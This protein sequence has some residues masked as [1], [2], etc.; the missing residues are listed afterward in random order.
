M[1]QRIMMFLMLLFP[2]LGAVA[3]NTIAIGNTEMEF[4]SLGQSVNLPVTMDNTDDIVAVE[5]ILKL[6]RGGSIN[7]D[8]CQLIASRADGHQISAACID[9]ENNIYKVTA[10]STSN[11]PFKASSGQLMTLDV[12]TSPDWLDGRTYAVTITKALLCKSNG[13]NVCTDFESGAIVVPNTPHAVIAF[14]ITGIVTT[15]KKGSG[16][17]YSLNITN[18]GTATTGTIEMQL[19]DWMSLQ[20][21]LMPIE[22]GQSAMAVI[23]MNPSGEANTRYDGYIGVN[24]E[25]GNNQILPYNVTIVSDEKGT[26]VFSVCDEYTYYDESAPKVQNATIEVRNSSTAEV[27]ATLNTGTTG[28]AQVTLP[29]GYYEF[30]VTAEGHETYT[31]NILIYPGQTIERTVNLSLGD[32]INIEYQVVETEEGDG[33]VIVTEATLEVAVPAPQVTISAPGR[34]KM[35]DVAVG[36]HVDIQVTLTNRG[37]IKARDVTLFVPE[38]EGFRWEA[39]NPIVFDLRPQE[40][41]FITIRYTREAESEG[42]SIMWRATYTWKCGDEPK[43][44]ECKAFTSIGTNC[45]PCLPSNCIVATIVQD[46]DVIVTVKMQ[47]NQLLTLTRQAFEGTLTIENGSD[48][49]MDD[50]MLT[51]TEKMPNGTLATDREFD[52]SYTEFTGFTGEVSGRWTLA[53]GEKGVLKVKFIPTKYAAPIAAIDY[54]FGGNL[55]FSVDGKE[56]HADLAEQ[57]M[58]VKPTPELNLD[59]FMQRDVIADDA[60]TKDVVEPAEEAEFA[61]LISNV[62]YGDAENLKMVTAQPEIVDNEESLFLQYS[63]TSS[64]LNG[65]EKSLAFGKSVTTDFGTL[66]ARS[67]AYAQWWMTSSLL[68]HFIEYNVSYTQ[69][70][71]SKNPNLS[72]LNEV[73][74]HELI[75]SVV[76]EGNANADY[77]FAV[78]E[79][80]DEQNLPDI[81]YLTDGTTVPIAIGQASTEEVD[82]NLYTITVEAAAAGWTYAKMKDPTAGTATIT[83]VTRADGTV[84]PLRNIWQ[85]WATVVDKKRAIHEDL[86]HI[87]DN[88]K[89]GA[90]TYT[91]R[92]K[93]KPAATLNIVSVKING[94]NTSNDVSVRNAEVESVELFFT[95]DLREVKPRA[96]SLVNQGEVVEMTNVS[97]GID[98]KRLWVDLSRVDHNDGF[99][100]LTV[101]TALITDVDGNVGLT[102]SPI[103]WIEQ[104]AKP[105][106]LNLAFNYDK[107][108][109]VMVLAEEYQGEKTTYNKPQVPAATYKYGTTLTLQVTPAYGYIF[110][111]WSID[112][113]IVSTEMTY[114]YYLSAN[115]EL[116]LFFDRE[117]FNL[118][119]SNIVDIDDEGL[120]T[121]GGMVTGAGSGYY[122]YG[123]EVVLTAEP[124]PCHTFVGWYTD[125][126]DVADN[127]SETGDENPAAARVAVSRISRT[128]AINGLKLLTTDATYTYIMSAELTLYPVFHRL[129][130]VNGDKVFS[131]ADA[132]LVANYVK[133]GSAENF[134]KAEAD[135]DCNGKIDLDDVLLIASTVKEKATTTAKSDCDVKMLV[136]DVFVDAGGSSSVVM[137]FDLGSKAYTAYQMDIIY[138]EGISSVSRQDGNPSIAREGMVY[139]ESHVISSVRTVGGQDRIQCFADGSQTL[140]AQE[141][142]LL[143]LPVSALKSV[144]EGTYRA[145]IAPVE[146]VLPDA[147]AERPDTI[148]FNIRVTA[149]G[150]SAS[151]TYDLAEGW[152]WISSN[153]AAE[154]TLF[155]NPVKT[156]VDRLLSQTE[157]LISDPLFGM[158]GNLTLLDV[159][160]GYK[161]HTT[162]EATLIHQ[163]IGVDAKETIVPLYQGWN[164]I[165]YVP[166]RVLSVDD[167]FSS[168]LAV[169]GD[170][171]VS[172]SGFATYD[173]GTWV[174]D[175]TEMTP[176]EGYMYHRVG[177]T[178]A[179]CYP[180]ADAYWEDNGPAA[181]RMSSSGISATDN[182]NSDTDNPVWT[183]DIHRY[184]DVTTIIAQLYIDGQPAEQADYIV[185]AFCGSDC[186][187]KGQVIGGRLFITIHGTVADN[188][189][190]LFRAYEQTTGRMLDISETI[191]F[192]GQCLGELDSPMLL[193][194]QTGTTSISGLADMSGVCAVYAADGKRLD[195]PQ[196]GVNIVVMTDGT[197]QKVIVE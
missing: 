135:A 48:K 157:E 194:A 148:F 41:S 193:H 147:T 66:P 155:I 139:D 133:D 125:D 173:D 25:N 169:K 69:L 180:A 149:P 164:W 181:A 78:N 77:A 144:A 67:H 140:V 81:L 114:D 29:E 57:I 190:I 98:G 126:P 102:A 89:S 13:D 16:S 163:G 160:T 71:M 136:P 116:K 40:T 127:D 53:A 192:Q 132:V 22:A 111:R 14:D 35:S 65:Q 31:N 104:T 151:T 174:G 196:R 26:V 167:A 3:Q 76:V 36:E 141:G 137:Y 171:L 195:R 184:P 94:E 187:G 156:R 105:V 124:E 44:R 108:A 150:Q 33:Y 146:F 5:L 39:L 1:K 9:G 43:S 47:F 15:V 95:D 178:I 166:H 138:P 28:T 100:C 159:T 84:V 154:P 38:I 42:C 120:T 24:I 83:E 121:S 79:V 109:T 51:L 82:E 92:F 97:Y 153:V 27:V 2:T 10:F 162:A 56:R 119:V 32:G 20:G 55:V 80:D 37:L 179:F 21:A 177:E 122:E 90:T 118:S 112:G 7:A 86:I 197:T 72:L 170:R 191:T 161:M 101:N 64:Q 54:V 59:Y 30:T 19:P 73:R 106:E 74:I 188:E 168:L 152:N 11:K 130:D 113:N 183:C 134:V 6:P 68:G 115:K 185:G 58:T 12:V 172:Q 49:A 60:I 186:R 145:A 88:C 99:Y 103:S 87:I 93:P 23:A 91:V 70:T 158:V 176:G 18:N 131:I 63:I 142:I 175:L 17:T 85:T 123:E 52:I 45:R 96:L 62:G 75:R 189:A 182:N 34:V 4:L 46:E 143:V 165:G 128:P 117:S 8:G 107:A 61:V 50:I 110:N 129:G